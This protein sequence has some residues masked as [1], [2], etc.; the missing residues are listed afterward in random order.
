MSKK[1]KSFN[2]SNINPTLDQFNQEVQKLASKL[3]LTAEVGRVTWNSS[4]ARF[5]LT[6][7]TQQ[8]EEI[9]SELDSLPYGH[10]GLTVGQL[11]HTYG[12]TYKISGFNSRA[13]KY[14]VQAV[15]R[16]TG[17]RFKFAYDVVADSLC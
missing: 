8:K 14:P 2:R 3:G 16:V 10:A 12:K 17:D 7:A 9:K 13:K 5:K 6:L 4:E 1:I 15:C 11:F